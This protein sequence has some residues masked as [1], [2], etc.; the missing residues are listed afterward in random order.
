MQGYPAPM[1]SPEKLR[2]ALEAT[3]AHTI[4]E[5]LQTMRAMEAAL[6][7]PDLLPDDGIGWFHRLYLEVTER[8]REEASGETFEDPEFIAVLDVEFA[9]LYFSALQQFLAGSPKTPRAWRPLFRESENGSIAPIQFALAGMNAHIN[10]DLAVALCRLWS[11]RSGVSRSRQKAD[12]LK[13]ND[14]LAGVQEE[15]KSLFLTGSLR[16]LDRAFGNVD[17][18]VAM[19]SIVEA[20]NAAWIH[21]EVL[22]ALGGESSLLGR[23]HLDSIDGMVGLASR[24]LL[25]DLDARR[26]SIAP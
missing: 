6:A 3:P 10:R 26:G 1:T 9:N 17:D 20:R 18:V 15:V 14:L 13:I 2:L 22:H 19:W 21:G 24:G 12:F 4:D 25:I 11:Q 16:R 8:V 23:M 5:V 7:A